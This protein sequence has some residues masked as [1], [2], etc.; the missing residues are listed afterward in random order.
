LAPDFESFLDKLYY[1]EDEPVDDEEENLSPEEAETLLNSDDVN[2]L[3]DTLYN[4]AL[5]SMDRQWLQSTLERLSRHKN[6]DIREA[7]A[8]QTHYFFDI[9]DNI[10]Q[11]FAKKM[12]ERFI[13]DPNPDVVMWGEE[14]FETLNSRNSN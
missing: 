11:T 6:E 5:G 13:S 12:A 1:E 14:I 2:A 10:D 4:N 8:N 7:V 3:I 9:F